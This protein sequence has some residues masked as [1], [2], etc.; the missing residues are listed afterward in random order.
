MSLWD[1]L[2]WAGH[3]LR[4]LQLDSNSQVQLNAHFSL[5]PVNT[6]AH[7]YRVMVHPSLG[8]PPAPFP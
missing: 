5:C 7:K 6:S 4:V 8:E 3:S 2:T 1:G